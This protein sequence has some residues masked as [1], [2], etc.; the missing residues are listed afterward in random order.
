MPFHITRL[1]DAVAPGSFSLGATTV[2]VEPGVEANVEMRL[3]RFI[4]PT[5]TTPGIVA[6]APTLSVPLPLFPAATT[7]STFAFS[8]ARKASSQFVDH[9]SRFITSDMTMMS[10]PFSTAQ[11]TPSAICWSADTVPFANE[12]EMLKSF[13]SGAVPMIPSAP[14]PWP[15]ARAATWVA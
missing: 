12:I 1:P 6:G 3:S 15:A 11:L 10:A 2:T 7:T 4:P 14:T 9:H 13:A 8:A 5:T